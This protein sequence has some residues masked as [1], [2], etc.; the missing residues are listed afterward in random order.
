MVADHSPGA[1]PAAS[2]PTLIASIVACAF[3]MQ[4][5][6]SAIINTSLPQ[7]AASFGVRPLDL[8]V[9]VTIYMMASAAF[10]PLSGWLADRHG[11][12][13]VFMWAIAVFALS[14]VTCG[15]SRSLLQFTLAR[16]IQ[17]LGGALMTP[18]GRVVVLRN[19]DKAGLLRATALITWPGLVAPVIAPV[20]GGFIT[21][22]A[23]WRWNFFLNVPLGLIGIALVGRYVPNWI[24]A[25]VRKL[26]WHG[27]YLSACALLLLLYGLDAFTHLARDWFGPTLWIVSGLGLGWMAVRHLR[28][29]AAPLLELSAVRV[30]TFTISTLTAGALIRAVI[31][32]TPFLLPLMFQLAFGLDPLA[33]GALVFAYF[34]GNLGIKPLTSPT[35]RRFGFRSVLV[36]NGVAAGLSLLA[37]AFLTPSS[38]HIWIMGVLLFAGL[39]RSMQFTCLNTLSFADIAAAQRSSASTLYS[40][41]QQI[42][43]VL[44]V[45]LGALLLNLCLAWR[46]APS[47]KLIDFRAAFIIAAALAIGAALAFL[48]LPHN[49]GA[50]V[51]GHATSA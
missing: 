34:L 25:A 6:D 28:R 41:L 12:R 42:V 29:S 13:N 33:S 18:V 23:N 49:A 20:L 50:E 46:H 32:A 4:M 2:N 30:Q 51:S 1:L 48:R 26:D 5:L 16:A 22:Y 7:M 39:T 38:P 3:F 8:S 37:C 31:N 44:G 47:V 9:G 27:F 40:M 15:S 24:D 17:G 45:A 14:S 11:S 35:L 19:T 36:V 21:T 10:V 43:S